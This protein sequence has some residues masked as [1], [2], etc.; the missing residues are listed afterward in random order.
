MRAIG[1]AAAIVW[2]VPVAVLE[3]R[4]FFEREVFSLQASLRDPGKTGIIAEFK[5]RSPS[6]GVIND[7]VSVIDV[8]K[9]YSEAGAACLSVLT[10]RNF[11]GGNPED[12]EAARANALPILRKDFIID[13][14]QI[15]EARAM[16][17]D[18]IGAMR[19]PAI[20]PRPVF[21]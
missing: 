13:E 7:K 16:G 15:L 6:K 20:L 5:R 19:A 18:V 10:D 4:P 3:K 8:T 14:Y 2:A 1:M 12:L 9:G 21:Q 11:F 17:A